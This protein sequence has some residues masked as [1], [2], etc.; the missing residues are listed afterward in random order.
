MPEASQL[1]LQHAARAPRLVSSRPRF[2]PYPRPMPPMA[3]APAAS[4]ST[5]FRASLALQRLLLH[6]LG[7]CCNKC[8]WVLSLD[9]IGIPL[10]S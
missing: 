1:A 6:M 3:T 8:P 2:T 7:L 4:P 10:V 5:N 9:H